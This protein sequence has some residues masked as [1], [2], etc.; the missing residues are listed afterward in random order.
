S[1]G[2]FLTIEQPKRRGPAG[3]AEA[4][5]GIAS[6]MLNPSQAR[7]RF[8]AEGDQIQAC[9]GGEANL[10]AKLPGCVAS[11]I[12]QKTSH[13]SGLRRSRHKKRT[14][15]FRAGSPHEQSGVVTSCGVKTCQ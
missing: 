1:C 6:T 15:P 9:F 14:R 13:L 12:C 10:C 3:V 4:P 8:V 2:F 11:T 5:G 7:R